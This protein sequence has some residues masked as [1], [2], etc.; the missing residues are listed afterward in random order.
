MGCSRYMARS[1]SNRRAAA[2]E[3]FLASIKTRADR[4]ARTAGKDFCSACATPLKERDGWLPGRPWP[5][6]PDSSMTS[7]HMIRL[8]AMLEQIDKH[9]VSFQNCIF[10]CRVSSEEG[11]M[12]TPKRTFS[13][14]N[15]Q[16]RVRMA[17]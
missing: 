13:A 4:M 9:P 8:S 17:L 16:L 10:E 7:G 5:C 15:E 3:T 6:P 11:S 12:T 14:V 2:G 1:H